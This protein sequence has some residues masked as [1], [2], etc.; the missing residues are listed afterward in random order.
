[1]AQAL[2]LKSTL[3][4]AFNLIM[5]WLRELIFSDMIHKLIVC[6][7][8]LKQKTGRMFIMA[9]PLASSLGKYCTCMVI[10]YMYKCQNLLFH[11]KH[12]A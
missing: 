3:R 8:K 5:F 7:Y 4:F 6:V 12:A 1:M 9:M 2:R 11:A 10:T